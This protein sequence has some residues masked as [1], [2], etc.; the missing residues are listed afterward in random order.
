MGR[1]DDAT[2]DTG[3][4]W[5]VAASHL[6]SVR[7]HWSSGHG[8]GALECAGSEDE[9]GA[10]AVPVAA[11]QGIAHAGR[12]LH[13]S[14]WQLHRSAPTPAYV[15]NFR[16]L[17]M[18]KLEREKGMDHGRTSNVRIVRPDGCGSHVQ[19]EEDREMLSMKR[20]P[21]PQVAGSTYA[22]SVAL[23]DPRGRGCL[24]TLKVEEIGMMRWMSRLSLTVTVV[25]LTACGVG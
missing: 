23:A 11:G 20:S 22:A 1:A 9:M 8:G 13:Y 14:R 15:L 7:R 6:D 17:A 4:M 19:T 24:A 16:P 5:Y 3:C 2:V 25:A 18:V 10:T 21:R 12:T